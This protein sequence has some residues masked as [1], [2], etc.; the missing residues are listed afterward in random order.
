VKNVGEIREPEPL[1]NYNEQKHL[2]TVRKGELELYENEYHLIEQ[3]LLLP[4]K[5]MELGALE[6]KMVLLFIDKDYVEPNSEKKT[7]NDAFISFLAS[8]D[9]Q[10][11]VKKIYKTKII[12]TGQDKEG[13]DKIVIIKVIDEKQLDLYMK[14]KSHA[15]MVWKN[16]NL[17]EISKSMK[18]MMTN[19]GFRDEELL[20]QQ[21]LSD[22]LSTTRDSFTLSNRRLAVDIKGLKKPMGLQQINVYLDG[23]GKKAN[24][25]IVESTGNTSYEL[26]PKGETYE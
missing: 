9:N 23:G 2:E 21:I 1:S 10:A 14:L 6:Q 18:E 16:S 24:E 15:T 17:K 4:K 20:E 12:V 5:F 22:A 7:E 19:S 11:V 8:Y 3:S 26:I 13:N 25:I